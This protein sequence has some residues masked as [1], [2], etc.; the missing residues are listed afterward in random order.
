[1]NQTWDNGEKPNF[2]SDFASFG[3]HLGPPQKNILAYFT[4]TSS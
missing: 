1:M 2:G 3:Q 4:S